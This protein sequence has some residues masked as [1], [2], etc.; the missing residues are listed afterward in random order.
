MDFAV[1]TDYRVK[2]KESEKGDR[3]LNIA[4]ELKKLLNMKVTVIHKPL[5]PWDDLGRMYV[6]RK[7]RSRGFAG[8]EDI[9]DTSMQRL[10][11]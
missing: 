10:E 7:E 6:S 3:Y 8:T 9:V 2:I 4:R 5:H 11:D 1:P